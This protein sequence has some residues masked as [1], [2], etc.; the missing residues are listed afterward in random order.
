MADVR[1]GAPVKRTGEWKDRVTPQDILCPRGFMQNLKKLKYDS[2]EEAYARQG[3]GFL[4]LVVSTFGVLGP[5][6]IR[7]PA[8]LVLCRAENY[9]RFRDQTHLDGFSASQFANLRARYLSEIFAHI[10]DAAAKATVMRLVGCGIPADPSFRHVPLPAS[11]SV[12]G[13]TY[14]AFLAGSA[15]TAPPHRSPPD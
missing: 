15:T 8:M 14:A 5:T 6:L 10:C 13:P 2:Y 4:A 1:I 3:F 12:P 7:Y 9:C 11:P